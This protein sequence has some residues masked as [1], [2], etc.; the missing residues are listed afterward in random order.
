MRGRK[1]PQKP[2]GDVVQLP[3]SAVRITLPGALAWECW[4]FVVREVLLKPLCRWVEATG[5][6]KNVTLKWG[7]DRRRLLLC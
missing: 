1:P 3:A 5:G 6:R 2:F 4:D 7:A